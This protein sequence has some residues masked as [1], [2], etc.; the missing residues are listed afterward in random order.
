MESRIIRRE[1]VSPYL[2]Q[3]FVLIML[4]LT[5]A[6][7]GKNYCDGNGLPEVPTMGEEYTPPYILNEHGKVYGSGYLAPESQRFYTVKHVV[8]ALGKCGFVSLDGKTVIPL[9]ELETVETVND[10]GFDAVVAFQIPQNVPSPKAKQVFVSE[11]ETLVMPNGTI[12][13]EADSTTIPMSPIV[14]RSSQGLVFGKY[15]G[16]ICHGNSGS[17]VFDSDSDGKAV[18][19]LSTGLNNNLLPRT[20]YIDGIGVI[21]PLTK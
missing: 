12:F 16:K 1:I 17:P 14:R 8:D 3:Y 9:Q 4:M 5:L 6:S 13:R 18:G 20:C 11:Q 7:C 21:I 15:T 10:V 19:L 2:A